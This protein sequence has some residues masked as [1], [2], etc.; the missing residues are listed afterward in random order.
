MPDSV[1]LSFLV[2]IQKIN[3]PKTLSLSFFLSFYLVPDMQS[4]QVA[5]QQ[6]KVSCYTCKFALCDPAFGPTFMKLAN[7][8]SA[9]LD[10]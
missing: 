5:I 10:V 2:N 7:L 4:L 6:F 3:K 1:T 8:F 9:S